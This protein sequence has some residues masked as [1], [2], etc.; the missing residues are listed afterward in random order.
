LP[1]IG[2]NNSGQ[3]KG[4]AISI[5]SELRNIKVS[6]F[7]GSFEGNFAKGSDSKGGAIYLEDIQAFKFVETQ[8]IINEANMGGAIFA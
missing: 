7:N 3:P 2:K 1:G 8:F 6:I 4:G 5:R